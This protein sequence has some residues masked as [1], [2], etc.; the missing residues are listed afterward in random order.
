MRYTFLFVV[1]LFF[2][3]FDAI[4]QKG[5]KTQKVQ[6]QHEEIIYSFVTSENKTVV[7]AFEKQQN[8]VVFRYGTNEKVEVEI[9][10]SKTTAEKKFKYSFF[11]RGTPKHTNYLDLNYLNV[12]VGATQYVI[13]EDYIALGVEPEIGIIITDA[14]IGDRKEIKGDLTTKKGSLNFF[15]ENEDFVEMSTSVFR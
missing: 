15:K 13:F 7:I 10:E 1:T 14:N 5:Q 3:S 8:Y 6:P 11:K 9:R 4:A 12:N 2:L